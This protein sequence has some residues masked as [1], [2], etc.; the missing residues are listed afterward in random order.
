[1][2]EQ[3]ATSICLESDEL[4]GLHHP[5]AS[6]DPLQSTDVVIGA[7]EHARA[8]FLEGACEGAAT[9]SG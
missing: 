1:M 2:F 3:V 4:T 9:G 6:I 7:S 8:L 5:W